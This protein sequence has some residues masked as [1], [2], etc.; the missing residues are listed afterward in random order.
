M[1][2]FSICPRRAA[3]VNGVS[4]FFDADVHLAAKKAQAL[5]AHHRAGKQTRF[6]QNLESVAD[7][8]HQAAATR[9]PPDRA[10]HRRKSRDRA[11]A[12]IVAESKSAGKNDRVAAGNLFGLVPDEFDGLVDHAAMA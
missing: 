12:Q 11:G 6:E 9:E 3:Q 1:G 5:V 4:V 7:A 10:H 2:I 8:Q